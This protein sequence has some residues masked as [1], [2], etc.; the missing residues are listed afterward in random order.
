MS[1]ASAGLPSRSAPPLAGALPWLTLLL[2]LVVGVVSLRYLLPV[3]PFVAA[4]PNAVLQPTWLVAHIAASSVALMLGAAQFLIPRRGRALRLH[5]WLGRSY[6]AAVLVGA[7]SALV[8]APQVATGA[9][10]ALGFGLLAMTWLV[11]TGIALALILRRDVTRHR[12]WMLRSYALAAA[13]ITLRLYLPLANAADIPF[14]L[15]YPVIAWLCWV[16]NLLVME[17]WL[18]MQGAARGLPAAARA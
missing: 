10:A 11:A 7:A 14:E 4:L 5:R 8:L 1:L 9:V 12:R 18:R 17:I 15:S 2:A 16:P 3:V 13:A 6:V